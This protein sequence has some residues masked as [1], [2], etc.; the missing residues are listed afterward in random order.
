MAIEVDKR[1]AA[2]LL[3]LE[4]L[5]TETLMHLAELSRKPG[6]EMKLRKNMVLIKTFL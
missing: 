3:E 1:K 2:A 6:I 5:S 4:K